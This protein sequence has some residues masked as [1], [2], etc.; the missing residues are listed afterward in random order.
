MMA[1]RIGHKVIVSFL[2]GNPDQPIVT[3]RTYHAS[4]MTLQ[5]SLRVYVLAE[6]KTKSAYTQ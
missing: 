2:N 5:T 3:G 1:I 4:S 6:N